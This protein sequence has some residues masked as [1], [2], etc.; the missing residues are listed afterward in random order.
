MNK[1]MHE[2]DENQVA[3]QF[4]FQHRSG[5]ISKD[6]KVTELLWYIRNFIGLNLPNVTHL[7]LKIVVFCIFKR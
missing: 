2:T 5:V 4:C 1:Y 3:Y 6:A 7:S